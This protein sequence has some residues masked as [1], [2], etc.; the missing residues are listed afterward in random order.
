VG[1]RHAENLRLEQDEEYRAAQVERW[2]VAPGNF[3]SGQGER[4]A[5]TTSA[6]EESGRLGMAMN[7]TSDH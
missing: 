6:D 7:R 1:D 3:S 5:R 2:Y 4:A